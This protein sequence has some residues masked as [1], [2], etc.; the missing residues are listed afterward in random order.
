MNTQ[1]QEDVRRLFAGIRRAPGGYSSYAPHKPLLLLMALA[2]IQHG[3]PARFAFS[4]VEDEL[5]DL[6]TEFGPSNAP[7]P[8]ICLSDC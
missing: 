4:E 6:L 2:R 3:Q 5:K 8:G 1:T 7:R